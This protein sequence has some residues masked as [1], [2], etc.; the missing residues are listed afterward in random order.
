MSGA[1][2]VM[3]G[4]NAPRDPQ[5]ALSPLVLTLPA[6][7][8]SFRLMPPSTGSRATRK[9]QDARR[10][11][12]PAEATQIHHSPSPSGFAPP[13]ARRDASAICSGV[14][15]SIRCAKAQWWPNGSSNIP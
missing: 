15:A 1:I 10:L 7:L 3:G 5:C 13:I 4:E 14:R 9:L 8:G 2:R 11:E 6:L 12:Y